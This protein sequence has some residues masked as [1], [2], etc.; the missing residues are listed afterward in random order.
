MTNKLSSYK[1]MLDN[2]K[3]SSDWAE[4]QICLILWNVLE[5]LKGI[6][7]KYFNI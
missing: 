4:K 2:F 6:N 3:K 7:T 5:T 1:L